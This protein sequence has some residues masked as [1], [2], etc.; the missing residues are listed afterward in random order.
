MQEQLFKWYS[1]IIKLGETLFITGKLGYVVLVL[2]WK[3]KRGLKIDLAAPHGG[4]RFNGII[5]K[6]RMSVFRITLSATRGSVLL[7]FRH[8]FLIVPSATFGG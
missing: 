7:D 8:T 2:K 6:V 5:L 1:T 4:E 3:F